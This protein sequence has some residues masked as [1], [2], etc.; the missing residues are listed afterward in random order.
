MQQQFHG[1]LAVRNCVT[2]YYYVKTYK[3]LTFINLYSFI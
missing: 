1:R 2:I 3:I